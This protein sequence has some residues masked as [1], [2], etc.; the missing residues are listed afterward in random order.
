M[1]VKMYIRAICLAPLF[2]SGGV[3]AAPY[4]FTRQDERL[5]DQLYD[6]F[7]EWRR[8]NFQRGNM[9]PQPEMV[10]SPELP[11]ETQSTPKLQPDTSPSNPE[12]E[13]IIEAPAECS[14]SPPNIPSTV[15]SSIDRLHIR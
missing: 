4:L 11:G 10:S 3:F 6:E 12:I 14:D 9:D 2:L 7:Q 8:Q 13:I 15:S 5:I 1:L